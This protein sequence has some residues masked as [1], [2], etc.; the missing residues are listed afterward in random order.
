MLLILASEE[1]VEE[2]RAQ[3]HARIETFLDEMAALKTALAA[4]ERKRA[5]GETELMREAGLRK[6]RLRMEREKEQAL[7]KQER[8]LRREY[9]AA[10][11]KAMASAEKEFRKRLEQIRE[12]EGR[13]HREALEALR[14]ALAEDGPEEGA[15]VPP[16]GGRERRRF[17]GWSRSSTSTGRSRGRWR[18]WSSTR[19]AAAMPAP[20]SLRSGS[21]S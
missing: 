14:A 6:L 16:D 1:A 4:E 19:R 17:R 21:R 5:E 18:R 7:D 2:A 20:T 13:R 12:E 15:A 3:E 9:D 11:V 10:L 8:S